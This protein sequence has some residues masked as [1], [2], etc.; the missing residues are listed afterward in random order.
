[1]SRFLQES[2]SFVKQDISNWEVRK[3][4]LLLGEKSETVREGNFDHISIS[5]IAL[6]TLRN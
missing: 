6:H 3:I 1:M 5:G 2:S 4:S